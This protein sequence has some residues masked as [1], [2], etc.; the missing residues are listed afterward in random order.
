MAKE[1][2]VG[3]APLVRQ[4]DQDIEQLLFARPEIGPN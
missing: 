4:R 1:F 2:F 3:R